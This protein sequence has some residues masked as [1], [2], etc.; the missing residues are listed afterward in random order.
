MKLRSL[1]VVLATALVGSLAPSAVAAPAP[2][3]L[4]SASSG[5]VSSGS[6]LAVVDR[7]PD[8]EYGGI[9]AR[10]QRLE[11]I[12]PSGETSTVYERR[13]SRKYGG[14]SLLDWSADGQTA[15]LTAIEHDA[16]QLIRVDIATGA[17]SELPVKLLNSAVLDPDGTGVLASS[18]KSRRSNTLVLDR[19]SWTGVRTRLREGV[20]GNVTA[21]RNG[22]VIVAGQKGRTQYVLSTADGSVVATLRGNGY[23]NPVRWWD[24]SRLLEW[25]G[26]RGDLFLVDP[27][28]GATT[29]LTDKHGP[30]DYGH[31]D[32]R[33]VG[34]RLY[35]QVAGACGYTFV[36][37]QTKSG[38]MKKLRVPGAV[39]NVLMVDA[40]GTELVLEHAASCDGDRPRAVLSRFDPVHHEET[41]ILVLGRHEDFGR[42]LVYGEVRTSTY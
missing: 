10:T 3:L 28:T 7:G 24:A 1:L 12:S 20:S 29:R 11:L 5:A 30:G 15:L 42:I 4:A 32:A 40:V 16:T 2:V 41:P 33:Q 9:N 27:A 35:V 23:C 31:L 36:A 25:C 8:S 13:V 19:I 34:Q 18:W 39:G 6:Y 21:G 37:R 26:A 38:A 22:T 14:F 17:V